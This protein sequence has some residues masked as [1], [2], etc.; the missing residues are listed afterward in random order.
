MNRVVAEWVEKAKGDHAS[1]M[2]ELRARKNPNY[3]SACFQHNSVPRST[4]RG[5]CKR[6]N[7]RSPRHMI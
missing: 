3:D 2:R 6:G 5:F 7:C 1:A 4:S